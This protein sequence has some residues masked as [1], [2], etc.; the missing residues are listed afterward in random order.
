MV[1]QMKDG[2]MAAGGSIIE[3]DGMQDLRKAP[4]KPVF[5]D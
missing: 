4:G 5:T 3:G 2:I 1:D